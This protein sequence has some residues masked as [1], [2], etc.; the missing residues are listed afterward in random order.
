M[1]TITFPATRHRA[2][3]SLTL[4][5]A[6][7]FA[8]AVGTAEAGKPQPQTCTTTYPVVATH[9]GEASAVEVD[10]A[11]QS[12]TSVLGIITLDPEIQVSAVISDTGRL[13][14]TTSENQKEVNGI[15][16][17]V[18]IPS[19]LLLNVQLLNTLT[20][21]MGNLTVSEA[22]ILGLDLRVADVL[23]VSADVL[24]AT[25]KARLVT[26]NHTKTCPAG[27]DT[28]D[29]IGSTSL[30]G[31]SV[32]ANVRIKVLG[33]D[34]AV[35]VEAGPNSTLSVAAN[36]VVRLKHPVTG[37]DLGIDVIFNE[38]IKSGNTIIVNALHIVGSASVSVLKLLGVTSTTALT[39]DV[40]ISHAEASISGSCGAPVT[41]C[42]PGGGGG[43]T[44]KDFMTGVGWIRL[45]SGAKGNFGFNGGYK[46]NGLTGHLNF[47]DHSA[48]GAHITGNAVTAYGPDPLDPIM[49]KITYTCSTGTCVLRAGDFGEPGGGVDT[50]NLTAGGMTYIAADGTGTIGNG[51]VQLHRTDCP[52]TSTGSTKPPR[53]NK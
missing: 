51:N 37:V 26:E 15:Q 25:A 28:G 14:P 7:G 35:P 29:A 38:Q 10:A 27:S 45:D 6:A 3:R 16:A 21:S 52:A 49:R 53:G 13:G 4:L 9:D 8:F 31:S 43:C 12:S 19:T 22:N 48:G 41:T 30:K 18:A 5:V 50:L 32:I 23:S 34:V 11:I 20:K 33:I 1:N 47:N 2:R 36:T 39:L 40:V 42:G 17:T 44:P 46:P 24:Q